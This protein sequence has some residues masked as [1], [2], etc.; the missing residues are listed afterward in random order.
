MLLVDPRMHDALG[1]ALAVEALQLLNKMGVLQKNRTFGAGSL[2]V[3]VVA[4]R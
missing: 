1:Y 4:D 3:L 2:G